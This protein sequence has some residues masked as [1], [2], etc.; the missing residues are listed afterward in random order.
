MIPTRVSVPG[1]KIVTV[2]VA[3]TRAREIPDSNVYDSSRAR[4]INYAEF[5]ISLPPS[6]QPGRIEWPA[7]AVDP[8]HDFATVEQEVLDRD[9]FYKRIGHGGDSRLPVN[10]GIFVHGFN[11]NFQESLYRLAQLAADSDVK[12]VPILFAWP[13]EA[14]LGG[15]FADKD[16]VTFSRDQLADL[17]VTVTRDSAIG[18]VTLLGHSMGGWLTAEA[19]R[20]LRLTRHDAALR[21]LTVVLAAPDIDA[22]VFKSQMEV[23]GPLSPP[24]T[25][26]VSRQ[27]LALALSSRLA[28]NRP[29]IGMLNVDDPRVQEAA[30]R[31]H[32]QIID[33]A[34]LG[35]TDP[36]GHDG[37]VQFA[38]LY[39]RLS[40]KGP[41]N[42]LRQ[43]GAFVAGT[44]GAGLSAPF[45]LVGS[46]LANE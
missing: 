30:L 26:L 16:A 2:Y 15:Y 9:T 6:H 33:V 45:D 23:I 39:G 43:A 24:M 17:L 7:G 10:A 1:T 35:P 42:G 40:E 4:G 27:D 21:R 36:A 34:A 31:N 11:N 46:A 41:A 18:K 28:N 13:S 37:F 20:Q 44:V 3:T 5:K 38:S 25:I 14:K 32:L 12:G 22:D 19:L 8:A 29:R